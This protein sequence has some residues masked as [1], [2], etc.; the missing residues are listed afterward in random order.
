MY[1]HIPRNYIH[2]LTH[3]DCTCTV[4]SL[5]CTCSTVIV[6]ESYN[7]GC[8]VSPCQ[9]IHLA[10]KPSITLTKIILVHI[11]ISL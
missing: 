4:L 2:L 9:H 7:Y 1:V 5:R 10:I 3:V 8:F 11:H 6:G